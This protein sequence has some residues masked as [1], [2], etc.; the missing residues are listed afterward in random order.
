[1]N[2]R[3]MGCKRCCMFRRCVF[4]WLTLFHDSRWLRLLFTREFSLPDALQLWDALFA[5]DASLALA[6]WVCVAMLIRIRNECKT[7]QSA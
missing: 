3:S 2:L 5:C 6:Q 4:R 7:I 1:L